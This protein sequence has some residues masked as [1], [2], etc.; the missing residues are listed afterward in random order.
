MQADAVIEDVTWE[1]LNHQV[2]RC[3]SA[4]AAAHRFTNQTIRDL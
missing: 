3:Q 1:K 2:V 4:G